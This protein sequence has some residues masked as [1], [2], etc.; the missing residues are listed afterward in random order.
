MLR[1]V[2]RTAQSCSSA[3]LALH[4][5]WL[6]HFRRSQKPLFTACAE[7]KLRQC[8]EGALHNL[9]MIEKSR[10]IATDGLPLKTRDG[11]EGSYTIIIIS[12]SW[13]FEAAKRC[14]VRVRTKCPRGVRP[15]AS[16]CEAPS[17]AISREYPTAEETREEKTQLVLFFRQEQHKRGEQEERKETVLQN[18]EDRTPVVPEEGCNSTL[19][20]WRRQARKEGRGE[21]RAA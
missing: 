1:N 10:V 15:R 7:H 11:C 6:M 8:C 18:E 12:M 5:D 20:P 4:R 2:S 16:Q 14:Q 13:N 19:Y 21:D 17:P 3:D 9:R